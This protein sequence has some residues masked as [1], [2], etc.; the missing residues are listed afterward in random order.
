MRDREGGRG[1][2]VCVGGCLA[3]EPPEEAEQAEDDHCVR[4]TRRLCTPEQSIRAADYRTRAKL[5]ESPA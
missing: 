4:R 3:P 2:C 1:A 5:Y